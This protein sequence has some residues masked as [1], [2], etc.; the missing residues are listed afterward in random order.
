MTKSHILN[1]AA[2][3]GFAVCAFAATFF[4]R[5]HHPVV[6]PHSSDEATTTLILWLGILF[7]LLIVPLFLAFRLSDRGPLAPELRFIAWVSFPV[8][9]F[10]A[11][12]TRGG[13]M[14]AIPYAGAVACAYLFASDAFSAY[15]IGSRVSVVVASLGWLASALVFFAL[16]WAFF[17]FE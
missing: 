6:S 1:V 3:V 16:S 9:L 4:M 8:S 2:I 12:S 15:R 10:T 14:F 17:Y 5:R 7:L 11:L 13:A